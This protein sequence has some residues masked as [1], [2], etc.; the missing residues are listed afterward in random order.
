MLAEAEATDLAEDAEFGEDRRGDELPDALSTKEGRLKAIRAAK[1]AIEAEAREKAEKEAAEKERRRGASEDETEQAVT[2][3]GDAAVPNPRAQR[4][5]TDPDARMMKTADGSFHYA[6][7]AQTVVDEAHQVILSTALIQEPTDVNQLL[8]MIEQTTAQLAAS[9]LPTAPKMLL[10]DAGYCSKANLEDTA[11]LATDVLVA[12]GRM[13][14]NE[15]VREAPRGRIPKDATARDR[16]ARRLRTKAGRAHYAR[17]KAI[18]EPVFGQM[19]TRQRA[20][21]LR[22]RGLEGARGEWL[23]HALCHN[24]RK[25]ANAGSA[26]A[27]A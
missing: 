13:K 6:Y 27:V 25:L 7:N 15:A 8:P 9:S 4:S 21:A 18:V 2:A 23:L 14:H 11:V 24:L 16:M 20:G 3:A 19:K 26:L 22:L 10:A 1:A 12:T 5:F 17:R